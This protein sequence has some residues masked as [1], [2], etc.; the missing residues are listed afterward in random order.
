VASWRS[1]FNEATCGAPTLGIGGAAATLGC[2]GTGAATAFI[3]VALLTVGGLLGYRAHRAE[4]RRAAAQRRYLDGERA[5]SAAIAPLWHQHIE[6]SRAQMETA[7]GALSARFASIVQRLE[8][9]LGETNGT[10]GDTSAANGVQGVCA[11]SAQRLAAL[12]E[13]LQAAQASGSAIRAQVDSLQTFVVELQDMAAAVGRIAQQTNLLAINAA[14][15]AAHA[16]EEGRGF[17][18]VAQEVR[19][20]SGQSGEVGARISA[21][22]QLINAAIATAGAA[23]AAAAARDS[24]GIDD[25]RGLIDQV[26]EEFRTLAVTLAGSAATLRDDGRLIR[27]EV[28]EALVQLQFQD[29]VGQ[30]MSHVG[31]SIGTLPAV[32]AAHCE[33]C[34][35]AGELRAL[36]PHEVRDALE[37]SYTVD[38]ERAAGSG[39]ARAAA[40]QARTAPVGVTF[41]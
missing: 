1:I 29:R 17:A 2:A 28:N 36:D 34:E 22:V 16:G 23:A 31:T 12:V 24:R 15:E 40:V 41:F 7:V 26:L 6:T 11:R 9:S 10:L 32:V 5:F 25:A 14:I 19:V 4:L 27:E 30:I 38:D 13:A 8:R 37:R 33:S 18:T 3:A 20:L 21:K 39:T 35:R